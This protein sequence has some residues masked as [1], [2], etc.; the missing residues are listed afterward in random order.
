MWLLSGACLQLR[1][2]FEKYF[3]AFGLYEKSSKIFLI[4]SYN[5]RRCEEKRDGKE[6]G[7]GEKECV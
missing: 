5:M 4:F 6:A 7:A 1:K 3:S 2:W